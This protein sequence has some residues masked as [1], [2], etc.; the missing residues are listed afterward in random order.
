MDNPSIDEIMSIC[1]NCSSSEFTEKMENPNGN[2]ICWICNRC[3]YVYGWNEAYLDE[4]KDLIEE[5][6]TNE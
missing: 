6:M 3:Y 5:E 1:P 2:G 4:F